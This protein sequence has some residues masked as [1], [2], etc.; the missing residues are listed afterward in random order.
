[1]NYNQLHYF[2][3]LTQ[4][5][6]FTKA[7]KA[8]HISQPS[9]S[10]AIR[11]LEDELGVSLFERHGNTL[12][13]TNYGSVF[14]S[15]VTTSMQELDKGIRHLET[16][17]KDDDH[18]LRVG[19]LYSLSSGFIPDLIAQ[20][21]T[22]FPKISFELYESNT[23]TLECTRELMDGLKNDRFDAI[24]VNRILG[25]HKGLE[26]THVF[27]Q[28]YVAVVANSS[29]LAH[30]KSIDLRDTVGIPL[31]QYK[32][33][34]GTKSEIASLFSKVSCSFVKGAELD[35]ESSII[36]YVKRDLGFAILPFSQTLKQ[37][38]IHV[39]PI[40]HPVFTRDIYVGIKASRFTNSSANKFVNW[41]IHNDTVL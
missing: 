6:H 7:A 1:M 8:L 2:I 39:I 24:F 4:H 38:G 26:F 35:D 32:R 13:L 22:L 14:A 29:R 40:H 21:K 12:T 37:S 16:M 9:L 36:N 41:I 31:I 3:T 5:L 10:I 28:N 20:F 27:E 17:K 30:Q 25:A 11:N 34:Y 15:Y 23:M 19:F 33:K 18:T